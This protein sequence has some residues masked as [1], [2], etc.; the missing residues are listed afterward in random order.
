MKRDMELIEKNKVVLRGIY[1]SH[2]DIKNK[3]ANITKSYLWG[4][5]RTTS[6]YALK[7]V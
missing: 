2:I 7:G 1:T 3:T 4:A 5:V 6:K